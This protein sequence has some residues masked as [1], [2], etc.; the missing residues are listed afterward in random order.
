VAVTG[1]AVAGKG[2]SK[3]LLSNRPR[4]VAKGLKTVI[5]EWLMVV[6]GLLLF[7]QIHFWYIF[8]LNTSTF[9]IYPDAASLKY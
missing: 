7:V 5:R 6:K 1:L 3:A 9:A 4:R 8:P 2:S